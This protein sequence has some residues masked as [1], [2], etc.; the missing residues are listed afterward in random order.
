MKLANDFGCSRKTIYDTLKRYYEE[1][2]LQNCENSGR[3]VIISE[4]VCSHL[5]L[6]ARRHPFWTYK[7]L[8]AATAQHPSPSTIRRI[9]KRFGLGKRRSKQKI[10]IKPPLARKRL[11]LARKWR[12][13]SFQSWIFSDECSVQRTSNFGPQ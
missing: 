5:Y 3:P 8:S 2:T 13:E 4:R 6:Q 10:T 9:L 11:K 1:D 7:Q 12:R